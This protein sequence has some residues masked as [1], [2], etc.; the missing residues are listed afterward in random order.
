MADDVTICA[1]FA[2][3]D[4][5]SFGAGGT[6][7]KYAAHGVRTAL[8]CATRGEA[9]MTNGLAG[10]PGELARVRSDELAC[11]AEAMGLAEVQ[12]LDFA[13][14]KGEE[15]DCFDL[16]CQIKETLVRLRPAIV[17]TFDEFGVTRHPDHM[18]VHT[19]V[20]E[21]VAANGSDLGIQRLFFQV[22]TC[23]EEA[24]AEGYEYACVPADTVDVC[25]DIREFEAAKRA[26]LYCHR[27]QAVDTAHMLDLPAG[28]LA[29]EHYLLGWSADGRRL[30]G[31]PDDLL[32]GLQQRAG[33]AAQ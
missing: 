21:L 12:I 1:I 3:P 16:A 30:C 19:V 24:N 32:D 5:E 23:P 28:S 13:D 10:S 18:C 7:A 31:N 11:A 27:S 26:A 8:I 22:I 14:G 4:D 2:H 15:W 29:A 6:L 20:R 9:G 17:V 33:N 25:I